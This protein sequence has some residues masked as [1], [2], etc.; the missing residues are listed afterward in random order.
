MIAPALIMED[1]DAPGPTWVHWVIYSIPASRHELPE[2]VE[3]EQTLPSR[4]RQGINDFRRIGYGGPCPPP[5][6]PHRYYFRLY[7]LNT[8][9][10][11][12]PAVTRAEL[13]GA[14]RRHVLATAEHFGRYQRGKARRSRS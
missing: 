7:A 14:M 4:M 10:D 8:T 3:P 2:G 1:P 13:D 6:A 9:L 11:L 5:S 12:P